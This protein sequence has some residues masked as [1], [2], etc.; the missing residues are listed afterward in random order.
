MIYAVVQFVII[1]AVVGVC[2]WRVAQKMMPSRVHALRVKSSEALNREDLPEIVQAVG[3]ALQ[4]VTAPV[5]G[6]GS[7]CES[8]KACASFE[9]KKS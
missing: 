6:C 4:P 7:G 2:L 8:C 5:T 3:K 9:I 1:T